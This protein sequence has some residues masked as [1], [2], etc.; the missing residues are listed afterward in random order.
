MEICYVYLYDCVEAFN[1]TNWLILLKLSLLGQVL[2]NYG[3]AIILVLN[4][5]LLLNKDC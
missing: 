2:V 5:D 3:S 4:I 1:E